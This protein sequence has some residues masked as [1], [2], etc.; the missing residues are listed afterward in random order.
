MR[1]YGAGQGSAKAEPY[2][3]IIVSCSRHV[4]LCVR[5]C[6]VLRAAL[7]KRL[8]AGDNARRWRW[9][10]KSKEFVVVMCRL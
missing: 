1:G 10:R 8:R 5:M 2:K 3:E 7:S 6:G 9:K 4:E